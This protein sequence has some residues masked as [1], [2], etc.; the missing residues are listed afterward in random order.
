[1]LLPRGHKSY[2]LLQQ[3]FCPHLVDLLGHHSGKEIKNIFVTP[4]NTVQ[5]VLVFM[6]Q[7]IAVKHSP[8]VEA[9]EANFTFCSSESGQNSITAELYTATE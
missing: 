4:K 7:R 6:H 5:E 1:M 2:S 9:V 3:N 8:K